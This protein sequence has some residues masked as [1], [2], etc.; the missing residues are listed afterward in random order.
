MSG[1]VAAPF[2]PYAH[3]VVAEATTVIF[4]AGQIPLDNGGMLVGDNDI[5]AQYRRVLEQIRAIV[6]AAGGKL[7]D[8]CLLRHYVTVPLS[9]AGEEYRRIAD[10]RREFFEPPYPTSTTVQV[11]GLMQPGVL[12]EV[13]AVAVLGATGGGPT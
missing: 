9:N 1:E 11:A 8:V 6:E 3:G 7:R 13:E 10:V 12:I 5:V 4:V 2:G